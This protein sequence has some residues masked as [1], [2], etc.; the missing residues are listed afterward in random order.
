MKIESLFYT[1]LPGEAAS[2]WGWL[3]R[4]SQQLEVNSTR[5][6]DMGDD[7]DV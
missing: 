7:G 3:L 1:E 4:Y 5:L 2:S 6:Q